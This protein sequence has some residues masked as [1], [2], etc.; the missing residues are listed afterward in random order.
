MSKWPSWKV[1]AAILAKENVP[2]HY[3]MITEKVIE[4]GLTSLG[5]SGRTPNLTMHRVMSQDHP[6]F[7][8]IVS[9]GYFVVTDK[10]E[11][12]AEI[13]HLVRQLTEQEVERKRQTAIAQTVEQ[14]LDSLRNEEDHEW[15]E[16]KKRQR[17]TN[18]YER[19][20]RLRTQA[21]LI[22]GT[23]CMVPGCGFSFE[24]TYGERGTGYIEVHHLK[25]L[26]STEGDTRVNPRTDMVVVC[27]NCH[28]MIHRRQGQV[29][30]LEEVGKLIEGAISNQGLACWS[31]RVDDS[32]PSAE[33]R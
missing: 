27:S 6:D 12:N 7:F 33:K 5:E 20:A 17:Y 32:D 29:L 15:A 23:A 25:P 16:G 30:T 14:D 2:L 3:D 1:A 24:A 10:A 18:Y 4:T 13:G 21:V 22:H 8:E 11:Y 9:P 19:N 26:S 31:L 28:R